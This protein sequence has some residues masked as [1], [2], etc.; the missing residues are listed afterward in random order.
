MAKFNMV[1]PKSPSIKGSSLIKHEHKLITH[2]K[3]R[4]G[5]YLSLIEL[6]IIIGLLCSLH[7]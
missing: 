7:R 4:G 1:H 5:W 6:G 3:W 2:L